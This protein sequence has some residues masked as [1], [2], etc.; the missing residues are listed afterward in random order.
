MA[1]QWTIE[2]P[3]VLDVGGEGERVR[4]LK[5]GLVGGRVDVVTHDD[6]PAA[7][8]EVSEVRGQPVLV[9]WDGS[10][11]KISQGRD[12][13][14]GIVDRLRATFEGIEQNRV[15]I[16]VSIPDDATAT[17]STVSAD[18]LVAGVH[19]EV[20]ANTVSGALTLDDLIGRTSVNTVSGI[21]ECSRLRGP[22]HA[23][24]VSGTVTAQ[25]SELPE[26]TVHTVSGDVALDLTNAVASVSSNSV[27]G[28]VTVRAPHRGYDVRANT[29]GGQ[30]VVDGRE[31]RRGPYASGGQLTEGDRG[32]RVKANAVSGSIV[33]LRST[34][35]SPSTGTAEHWAI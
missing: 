20:K 5:V 34:A 21:V 2:E 28:D 14:S 10:T 22:L 24:S 12:S 35:G 3:R 15:V 1:Q 23:N 32:L 33:V 4:A 13:E 16:S 9:R 29:A 8:I 30:V 31:L 7:R 26:A 18:A 11:L 17:V 19:A 25:S 6:S 27:T